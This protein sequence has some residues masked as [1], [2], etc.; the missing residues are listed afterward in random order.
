MKKTKSLQ[1]LLFVVAI[2]LTNTASADLGTAIVGSIFGKK[3]VNENLNDQTKSVADTARLLDTELFDHFFSVSNDGMEAA[4]EELTR[5]GYRPLA[6]Q[7]NRVLFI[8]DGL[9]GQDAEEVNIQVDKYV[10]TVGKDVISARY[11][12][13]ANSR[14]H[15]VNLYKPNMAVT[16]RKSTGW[17]YPITRPWAGLDRCLIEFDQDNEVVSMLTRYHTIDTSVVVG[18]SKP[19]ITEVVFGKPTTNRFQDSLDADELQDNLIRQM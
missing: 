3:T 5:A 8:Q 6:A 19:V 7:E 9:K 12:K 11:V 13:F 16:I 17:K 18:I 4:P 10:S 15:R 1:Y 14:G 2:S